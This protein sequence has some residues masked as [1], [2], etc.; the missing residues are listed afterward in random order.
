MRLIEKES[1][2]QLLTLKAKQHENEQQNFH[3][4][5]H[6]LLFPASLMSM[7]NN[8]YSLPSDVAPLDVE[9]LRFRI[10]TVV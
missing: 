3:A 9:A 10:I 7:E 2:H 5:K 8:T 4:K 6:A 1:L